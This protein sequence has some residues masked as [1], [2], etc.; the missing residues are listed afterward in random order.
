MSEK[1]FNFIYKITRTTDGQYYIGMHSTNDM[2][3]GY[4]GG[5]LVISRSVKKYGKSAHVR[6]VLEMLP[7]RLSLSSREKEIITEEVISDPLCMNLALGG[8]GGCMAG[9][10][11]SIE[12]RAKMS[13]KRKLR[14]TK[15]ETRLKLS[16]VA[17][18]RPSEINEQISEKLKGRPSPNKGNKMPDTAKEA[19]SEKLK[20]RPSPNKG[21]AWSES[22]RQKF[23]D[24]MTA[25]KVADSIVP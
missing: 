11:H 14:V 19:I 20:G 12:S 8:V 16:I 3:D 7:N 23:E 18:N 5:G 9:R 6:D 21:K 13:A 2:D 25:R 24:A 4:L 15:P 22:R 10:N 1:Q 17:N